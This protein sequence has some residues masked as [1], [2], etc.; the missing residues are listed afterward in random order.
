MTTQTPQTRVPTEP[1]GAPAAGVA[2]PSA[3]AVL[4]GGLIGLVASMDLT[5]EKIRALGDP[6]YVPSCSI[7]PILSCGSVMSTPQ[8]L[9][10]GMPNTLFG[11][12]AFTVVTVS[13]VLAVA[14]VALPRWYWMGLTAGALV[15]AG[16]V[17]WLIFASLYR[18]GALCPYCMVVWVTTMALLVV[19][20]SITYRLR[21]TEGAGVGEAIHRWRWSIA[22]LWLTAVVLLILVRFQ[23]NWS[24]LFS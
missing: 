16:F 14:K 2:R 24:I 1:P 10:L 22:V 18:I 23:D 8:A 6:D 21:P 4:I 19:L 12:V 3:F 15:G 5:V 17:H 20:G 11:I 7:N 13:G 9:L